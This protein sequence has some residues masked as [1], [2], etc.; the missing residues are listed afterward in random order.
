MELHSVAQHS[1]A[2]MT[3]K[4]GRRGTTNNNNDVRGRGGGG[5]GGFGRRQKS[6]R[7]GERGGASMVTYQLCG[8]EG[9]TVIKCFKRFDTS[10]TGPPQKSAS[11]ALTSYGVD[12]QLVRRLRHH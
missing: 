11:S 4:G 7:G 3:A 8:K 10:F 9:H 5:C 6:G 12:K 1:S 2:N